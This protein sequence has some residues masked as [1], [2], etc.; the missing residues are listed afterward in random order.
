MTLAR[1]PAV[2]ATTLVAG[3][4]GA[5]ISHSLSPLIHNA[6]IAAAGI[7][8]V[9]VGFAPPLDGFTRFALGLRGGVVRGLNVTAPF[10]EEALTLADRPSDRARRAGAAN[11]LIFEADGTIGADNTDGE[12][13]LAAFA[14]Q[15]PGFDPAAGPAVILGAGGAAMGAAAAFLDAGAPAL[16]IVGRTA[17]R[18]RALAS[19]LGE[20]VQ[21]FAV[22]DASRALAD[23]AAIVNATPL[24]S[25]DGDQL[26]IPLAAAPADVVVV[27][28]V[29]RP[30]D[31]ALLRQARARGSRTVDGLAM[32]IG[33]ATPSFALLFGRRAPALDVRRLALA[34][35]ERR[36]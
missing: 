9:Y 24:G 23:A 12:G 18:A 11:L 29:Y 28:M 35:L 2:S 31:T 17:A 32:L 26:A 7:D 10:K 15:A 16:R 19:A 6:W 20:V 13:L 5:P 27:D 34:A 33:Q 22:E 3:V 14:A 4:A 30:L 8:A 36:S 21:A 25:N 1:T